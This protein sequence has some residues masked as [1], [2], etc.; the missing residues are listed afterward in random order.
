MKQNL[1]KYL[2]NTI[3]KHSVELDATND[4]IKFKLKNITVLGKKYILI[5]H[6]ETGKRISKHVKNAKVEFYNYELE[7]MGELGIFDVF[8]KVRFGKLELISR[9]KFEVQ[10]RNK[11]LINKKEKTI[12]KPY[13]T[14]YSNLSFILK[15]AF[16]D[17]EITDLKICNNQI[18][19]VGVLQ[20]F[21]DIKF[22]S[23]EIAAKSPDSDETKVFNGKYK[24]KKNQ[25]FF[26]IKISFRIIEEY[27]NTTW[28]L[29]IRLK[30]E[31]IILYSEPLQGNFLK[32]VDIYE[33]YP[34]N[35][36]ENEI[37][38]ILDNKIN[39]NKSQELDVVLFYISDSNKYIKF[40]VITKDSWLELLKKAKN[41][42]IYEKYCE[43]EKIDKNLIFFESFH[44]QFYS[45]NPKYIYEKMLELGY[46]KKYKFVWSYTGDQRIPGNPIIVTKKEVESYYKYLATS[47]FWIHNIGFLVP[48]KRKNVIYVHT[49]HGTPLKRMGSDIK[50]S[51]P[52][53]VAGNLINEAKRWD[54]LITANKYSHDIFKRVSKFKK[55]IL[56]TGYPANDIFYSENLDH[57]KSKIKSKL[58]LAN[59]KKIILYAPTFRDIARDVKGNFY[60][61]IELDLKS[62]YDHFNEDY[63]ILL[64]LHY[65]IS[66]RLII[67]ENLKEFVFDVSKY[68]DIHELCLISDVLIT[69]Y[70]SV[71]FDFAHTKNPIL[72]FT[73]D[74][75]AYD[76]SRGLYLGK[77]DLPGPLLFDMSEL[78]IGIKNLDE[79]QEKYQNSYDD[80]YNKYCNL[81][82]G[83]ASE[84]VVKTLFNGE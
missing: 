84:K 38:A 45:H 57:E 17:Q 6:R 65:M 59:N 3:S 29:V 43:K 21:N 82:H 51:S 68:D 36:L 37:L 49:T 2:K 20:L 54:Y 42:K 16:F 66:N 26:N 24:I 35:L 78:I 60:Q 9:T 7:K 52:L 15:D 48:K 70:S 80:F 33:K 28:Q 53:L 41:K 13:K 44:G 39:L 56:N 30:N 19:I 76:S 50:T 62:L 8:L 47:K 40:R 71:F 83:D 18:Q 58:E 14:M 25:I 27:L 31:G 73:P 34:L 67:P 46:D 32:N 77:K 10:N 1:K 22:D 72:F 81:G 23:I 4:S 12:L 11:N 69:D 64:R 79:I 75:K 63:I 74:I 5:K 55:K 61:D